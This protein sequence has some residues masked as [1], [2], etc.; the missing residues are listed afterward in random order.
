[1][2]APDQNFIV[3][4]GETAPDPD[5]NVSGA[6][7]Q[8]SA[9]VMAEKYRQLFIDVYREKPPGGEKDS[10]KF[11]GFVE[12]FKEF[13]EEERRLFIDSEEKN[14]KVEMWKTEIMKILGLDVRVIAESVEKPKE[15]AP[16]SPEGGSKREVITEAND[17]KQIERIGRGKDMIEDA[18]TNKLELLDILPKDDVE[19]TMRKLDRKKEITAIVERRGWGNVFSKLKTGDKVVTI[20]VPGADFLKIKNLNDKIFGYSGTTNLLELRKAFIEKKLSEMDGL[21]AKIMKTDYQ[22][23][24]IRIPKNDIDPESLSKSLTAKLK[25]IDG[26]MT[27]E[28]KKLI[29]AER[30]RYSNDP[31]KLSTLDEFEKELTGLHENEAKNEEEKESN[32][33][34]GG[35]R[36]TFGVAGVEGETMTDKLD[37][38]NRSTQAARTARGINGSYGVEYGK[39]VIGPELEQIKILR[40]SLKDET[41]TS[42]D[43]VTFKLFNLVGKYMVMNTDVLRDVRKGKFV[44]NAKS[45]SLL[46]DVV[47]YV[48]KINIIDSVKSFKAEEALTGKLENQIA[49]RSDLILKFLNLPDVNLG[50]EATEQEKEAERVRIRR[51]VAEVVKTEEKDPTYSSADQFHAKAIEIE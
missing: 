51:E 31:E 44:A 6:N 45:E 34:K 12:K 40:N 32:N 20:I 43:G 13:D 21:D 5:T 39:E 11:E 8:P 9:E 2:T 16:K 37:A 48:K 36:M 25:E 38:L 26:E 10:T 42:F 49:Y 47:T 4:P 24:T 50:P 28:I 19:S 27:D 29:N 7:L 22:S 18:S 35:Y 30:E 15:E 41:I 1:M 3:P 46:K 17:P 33:G 23:S 14:A